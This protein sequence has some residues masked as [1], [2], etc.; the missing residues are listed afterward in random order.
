MS[1]A[2]EFLDL[3]DDQNRPIGKAPRGEVRRNNLLHRGVGILCW[4]SS[5]QLYVHRRT[6]SKDLFPGLYDMMVG[7]AVEAGEPY[8]VAA[9]R[10]IGEELGVWGVEPRFL[11]EHL[12]D[13][14]QN[15]SFVQLFEVTWDGPIVWQPEEICWGRWMDFSEVLS[16]RHQV[17]IVP[18]GAEVFEAYLQWRASSSDSV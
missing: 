17:A 12:Y 5:G 18:D 8:A 2:K 7:G 6:E 15:R 10:E 11:L 9:A 3:V 4:N 1:S 13:G 16:W 14:P